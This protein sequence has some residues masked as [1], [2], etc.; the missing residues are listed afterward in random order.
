ARTHAAR[1]RRVTALLT[2]GNHGP[3]GA[4]DRSAA[5]LGIG[6]RVRY[7]ASMQAEESPGQTSS[8]VRWHFGP[9]T[10][11]EAQRRLERDGKPVR[12]GPRSFD[13]LLVLLGRAGDFVGK[14]ELL[15]LVWTGVVVEEGSVR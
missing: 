1:S 13:L 8:E 12:V 3:P 5:R 9:F 14:D 15:S 6:R 10:V 4:A 7:L 2:G 11:W